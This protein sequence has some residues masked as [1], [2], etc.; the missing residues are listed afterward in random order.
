LI[1]VSLLNGE[2]DYTNMPRFKGKE[3]AKVYGCLCF[4]YFKIQD[5]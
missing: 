4:W 3:V 5:G 2:P 1:C